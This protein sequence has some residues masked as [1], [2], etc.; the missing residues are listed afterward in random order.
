MPSVVTVPSPVTVLPE[1]L[2][3][4]PAL[5]PNESTPAAT[6]TNDGREMIDRLITLRE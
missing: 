2:D 6:A 4:A 3:T 1:T 5:V